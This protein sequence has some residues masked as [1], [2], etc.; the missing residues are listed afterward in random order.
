MIEPCKGKRGEEDPG[1][2]TKEEK[3]SHVRNER[4]YRTK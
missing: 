1:E 4:G 2:G 3:E